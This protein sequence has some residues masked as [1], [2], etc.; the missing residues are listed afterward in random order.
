MRL[1][2]TREAPESLC[3]DMLWHMRADQ[4]PMRMPEVL[5]YVAVEEKES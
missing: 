3:L 5:E 1:G 4:A 2:V